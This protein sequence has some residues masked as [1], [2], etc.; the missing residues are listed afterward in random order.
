[1]LENRVSNEISNKRLNLPL[2]NFTVGTRKFTLDCCN[3]LIDVIFLTGT[4]DTTGVLQTAKR[5]YP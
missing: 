1:M 3:L 4:R 5:S 2:I